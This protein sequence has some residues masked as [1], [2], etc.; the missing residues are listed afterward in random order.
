[1]VNGR[2]VVRDGRLVNQDLDDRERRHR[3][4]ARSWAGQLTPRGYPL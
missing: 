4:L 2:V 1:V 3:A